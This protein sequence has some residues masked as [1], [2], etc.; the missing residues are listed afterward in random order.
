MSVMPV[1]LRTATHADIAAIEVLLNQCYRSDQGWTNEA[2]LIAGIRTTQ[3]QLQQVIDEANHYLF[4]YPKTHNGQRDGVE[5]GE[6]LACIGVKFEPATKNSENLSI[7][8]IGMF[9]VHPEHQGQGVG[10]TLLQAVE[11]FAHRHLGNGHNDSKGKGKGKGKGKPAYQ[12]Q[13]SVLEQRP[14]L[15]AYYQ[16]RG[17]QLTGKTV[18]FPEDGNNGEPLQQGLKLMVLAK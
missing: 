14:E 9:A 3:V 6:I 17:Y 16:R 13:M 5:T 7:A 4:V 15:L 2:H 11:T 8:Y 18:P 1:F 10:N 12:L